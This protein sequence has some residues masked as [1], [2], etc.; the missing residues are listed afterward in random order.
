MKSEVRN[1][2]EETRDLPFPKLMISDDG[3]I[4]LATFVDGEIFTGTVVHEGD[5]RCEIGFYS[6]IWNISNFK[7]LPE[8]VEVVLSNKR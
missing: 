3:I 2:N 8:G 6:K 5:P 1:L 4:V 7:D